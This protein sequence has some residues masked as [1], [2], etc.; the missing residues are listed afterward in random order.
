MLR[1]EDAKVDHEDVGDLGRTVV[2]GEERTHQAE[3]AGLRAMLNLLPSPAAILDGNLRYES[4]NPAYCELTGYCAEELLG[5]PFASHLSPET[6]FEVDRHAAVRPTPTQ[7]EPTPTQAEPTPA[8]TLQALNFKRKDGSVAQIECR[9]GTEGILGMRILLAA[10]RSQPR[11]PR[12]NAE[13]MATLAHELRNPLNAILGWATT[14]SRKP[15]SPEPVMHGVQ[16]IE[17]NARVQAQLI[18]DMS[19]CAAIAFGKL[20]LA[21]ETI[22]PYPVVR[23]ALQ[24]LNTAAEAA[25][26]AIRASFGEESSAGRRGCGAFSANRLEP[27]QQRPQVVGTRRR[28]RTHGEA[29]RRFPHPHRERSWQGDR[30]GVAAGDFRSLRS[31][32]RNGRRQAADRTPSRLD[33]S[34]QRGE[35][36]RRCIHL[37]L[38][39]EPRYVNLLS[40]G[41]SD[42]GQRR[43]EPSSGL[44]VA[45]GDRGWVDVGLDRCRP[46][47]GASLI[48]R[49]TC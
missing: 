22:D 46:A 13:F 38:S 47:R 36:R 6:P 33:S 3:L 43:T 35:G 31:R 17:R 12:L 39:I 40:R 5:R 24:A 30:C 48:G 27:A 7:A 14:L 44:A 19:D 18:S 49:R 2:A 11:A 29:Q 32:A 28:G 15:G 42:E 21:A 9:I 37:E 23:A 4:V 16:A 8:H 41:T 45:P 25:G 10:E 26:I 20:R 1:A 34:V